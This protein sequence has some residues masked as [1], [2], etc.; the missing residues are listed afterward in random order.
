[1]PGVKRLLA[2]NGY[3]AGHIDG[4]PD[5]A[6][7]AALA[8]F[9]KRMKFPATAGNAE[10][11]NALEREAR[12]KIAP[13]G[14]TACNETRDVLLVALGMME[15]GKPVS[16]GWWTVESGLRQG[17]H[18]APDQGRCLSAGAKKERQHGGGRAAAILHHHRRLRDSRRGKLRCT[19]LERIRLRAHADQRP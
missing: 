13:A 7:G 18:H 11:F 2:D 12:K 9:R 1:M 5:K 19:W 15:G 10:L 6:T 3:K 8:D 4:K 16:R 17:H 14:Y